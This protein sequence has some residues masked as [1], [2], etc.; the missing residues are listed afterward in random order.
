MASLTGNLISSTY[1]GLLKTVDNGNITAPFK[2]ITDGDGNATALSLGINDARFTGSIEVTGSSITISDG[3]RPAHTTLTTGTVTVENHEAV[4]GSYMDLYGMEFYS[5]S[6]FLDI[7]VAGNAFGENR[8]GGVIAVSNNIGEAIAVIGFQNHDDW[9]DG[10]V[11]ILTPLQAQS[12][13]QVTGSLNIKSTGSVNLSGSIEMNGNLSFM[14]G[15]SAFIF[16]IEPAPIPTLGSA[17]FDGTALYI[18][19]GSDYRAIN[20]S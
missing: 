10:T 12:G 6:N 15:T 18:Y 7:T 2:N 8:D 11:S 1:Q 14:P 4:I 3:I 17:Y 20:F 19:D 9:T 5:G 13:L 16:P